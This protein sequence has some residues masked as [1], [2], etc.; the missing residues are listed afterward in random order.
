MTLRHTILVIT[1]PLVTALAVGCGSKQGESAAA[2]DRAMM[3]TEEAA[4]A[5]QDYAYAQKAEFVDEMR[6]ELA[7]IQEELDR[8]SARVER[9]SGVAKAEARTQLD[10]VREK[11]AQVNTQL[12]QAESANE[13]TWDD[14]MGAFKESYAA[15][16]DSF[17]KTRQ[18]MSD[19]I[20][21]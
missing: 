19:K 11:W 16:E 5:M 17:E 13:S 14:M 2:R 8:L 15:L 9:S 18:W 1:F 7:D 6:R 3:E 20:A 12:D 21:P 4:Q 10:A